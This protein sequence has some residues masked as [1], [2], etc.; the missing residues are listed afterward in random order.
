M[1]R[2]QA[3]LAR[4]IP[5]LLRAVD[6]KGAPFSELQMLPEN[7]IPVARADNYYTEV[8]ASFFIVCCF[9]TSI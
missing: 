6:W 9:I 7:A 3:G 2:H 5:I 4:V 1:Q 8:T